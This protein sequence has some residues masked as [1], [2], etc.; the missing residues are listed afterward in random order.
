MD[1]LTQVVLGAAVGEAVLGKKIGARAALWGAIA[2]TIPDLDVMFNFTHDYVHA[3]D[4]HRGF[5]HSITFSIL[6]APV[7][8]WIMGRIHRRRSVP[9]VDWVKLAFLGL[10]THPLLDN[11][12]TWGTQFFWPMSDYRVAFNSVFVIDPLYT[13]PFLFFLVWA[14]FVKREKKRRA[15]LN[16]I[17]IIYSTIYLMIG[18]VNKQ[19]V[20]GVF[21][22]NFATQNLEVEQYMTKPSPMNIILWSTTAKANDGY[23]VGHYS[24]LDNDEEVPLMYY[25]HNHHLIDHLRGNE[26]LELL[27][28]FNNGYYIIEEHP[29]GFILS[30]LRF[31]QLTFDPKPDTPFLFQSLIKENADGS[32]TI[33]QMPRS[34][35]GL[36]DAV[37][38]LWERM[39][40]I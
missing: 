30:D 32:L 24:L 12:T 1:S 36:G 2:G 39:K 9:Y 17:G 25:P 3:T 29:E 31:G 19:V 34:M 38:E 28:T 16:Y 23:Y 4:L 22:G 14:L 5:S 7:L 6:F 37:G 27:L 11:F 20:N 26:D 33:E 40:G 35:S 8:A 18:L 13:I 10:V 15:R 21:E